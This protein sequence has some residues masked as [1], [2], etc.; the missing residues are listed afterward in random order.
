MVVYIS[1]YIQIACL[2][3]KHTLNLA[4][5]LCLHRVGRRRYSSEV[6]KHSFSTAFQGFMQD[7][8]ILT[9]ARSTEPE[10]AGTADLASPLTAR[11]GT[12]KSFPTTFAGVAQQPGLRKFLPS[13]F[14]RLNILV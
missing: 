5:T 13:I 3:N 14:E 9:R 1:Q 2:L 4:Q 7:A 8:P 12:V 10:A 11:P 6:G